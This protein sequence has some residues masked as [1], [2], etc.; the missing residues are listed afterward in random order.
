MTLSEQLR[1][2]P[3]KWDVKVVIATGDKDYAQL[4]TQDVVLINTMGAENTWLDIE[5]LRKK[6]GVPPKQIIDYLALMGTRSIMYS[7]FEM[8]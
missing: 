3:E 5:G 8:R 1:S 7:A 2:L 4:V 6:F